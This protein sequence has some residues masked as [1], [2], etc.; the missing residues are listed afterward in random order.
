[1]TGATATQQQVQVFNIGGGTL[2][3]TVAP[4]TASWLSVTCGSSGSVP[5]TASASVCLSLDP[6]A[7]QPGTYHTP[8]TISAGS[9]SATVSVTLQVAAS[10]P[11]ILLSPG[12]MQ[13]TAVSGGATPP[14]Q[15]LSIFNIGTGTLEWN[16]Q[17]TS[18]NNWLQISTA[19]SCP[20]AGQTAQGTA[21]GASPG[22]L[23]VCVNLVHA[24][25]GESYGQIAV[26]AANGLAGNSGAITVLLNVLPANSALPEVAIPTGVTLQA[27]VGG[28]TQAGEVTLWSP[29]GAAVSYT[30]VAVV[31]S[32]SSSWLS[33]SP[34]SGALGANGNVTLQV[35]GTPGAL[36]AGTYDGQVRIGFGDGTSQVVNVIFNVNG[37]GTKAR[38]AS[39]RTS[40]PGC[41]G[42]Y[43]LPPQFINLTQSGFQVPAGS[44]QLLQVKVKDSCSNAIT[45]ADTG[46]TVSVV[47]YNMAT[48]GTLETPNLVY[49]AADG[50]WEYGWTPTAAEVGLVGIYAIAGVGIGGN[51]TGNRS[52]LW[53]GSVT[54]AVPGSGAELVAVTDA[55]SVNLDAIVEVNQ[56][57]AGS[58]I[59]IF[60][61]LLADG[62]SV[63][64]P[65]PVQAEG[66]TVLLGGT[67]L[68][69]EYVSP[70]QTNALV[71]AT[72]GL[73][74]NAP[75]PLKIQRD[76]TLSVN[77]LQVSVTTVQP[78]IFVLDQNS[79]GAVLIANTADVVAPVGYLPGSRPA[80]AGVD[81]I[82]I[83]C[84]GLGP[85]NNPPVDGQPAS[86]NPVSTTLTAPQVS[87]GGV[88]VPA[89]FSG[90][91][92]GSVALYQVNVQVPP[93]V[94]PGNAVPIV[95]QMGDVMSNTGYIAVQAAQ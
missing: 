9:Q 39:A 50:A 51:S 41:A 58:Y 78:A 11:L 75:L 12:A 88:T 55:A 16:A 71:P 79:Q 31:L 63:P 45:S 29:N 61:T 27:T 26:S 73:P 81:Y 82:E 34:S 89:A 37:V 57:A 64:Y 53:T 62:T 84:N 18:T 36:A 69:L 52:D 17:T 60:G 24:T 80:Q 54:A 68:L 56:V 49:S 90:L 43:V 3:Y 25:V 4:P 47:I 30:A 77:D 33:V 66:S 86:G 92:P 74:L 13:F 32:G 70:T 23:T 40:P 7:L 59:S 72:A 48:Q 85:V 21:G 76:G 44:V 5:S 91:S 15:T 20:G 95:I 10:D 87:I 14:A 22:I 35:Q 2:N 65:F 1:V 94:Q 83:F 93:G 46:A 42:G 28:T 6:S 19:G 38:G 8:L 67:P